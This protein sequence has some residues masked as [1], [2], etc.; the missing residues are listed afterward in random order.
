MAPDKKIPDVDTLKMLG[1]EGFANAVCAALRRCD[2]QAPGFNLAAKAK[3]V[4]PEEG[5]RA[6]LLYPAEAQSLILSG[7]KALHEY[8]RTG[9]ISAGTREEFILA[10]TRDILRGEDADLRDKVMNY[11]SSRLTA[12]GSLVLAPPAEPLPRRMRPKP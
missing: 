1:E 9:K 12:I 5:G 8:G 3:S 4:V 2:M 11:I 10:D 7:V 6:L